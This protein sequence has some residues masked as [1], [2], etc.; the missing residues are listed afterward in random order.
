[1]CTEIEIIDDRDPELPETFVVEIPPGPDVDPPDDPTTVTIEDNGEYVDV[2][3]H[4]VV[5]IAYHRPF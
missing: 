1:M 2:S 4:M 5:V 3:P